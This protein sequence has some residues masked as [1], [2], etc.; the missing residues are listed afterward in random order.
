M[1]DQIK[2]KH[3]SGH[4]STI[5]FKTYEQ[6]REALA[7]WTGD[8]I[9]VDEEPP[10][11][12]FEE[13]CMRLIARKG[14]MII[15]FTPLRGKTK[16]YKMMTE[17]SEDASVETHFL[18]WEQ[19]KHLDEETKKQIAALFRSN[20]GQL[21]ARMTGKASIATGLIYPFDQDDIICPTFTPE[22]YWPRLAG[23]DV[24][25]VH[26]T[27]ALAIAWDRD[28]NVR[29]AYKEHR[30]TK[31]TAKDNYD[32]LQKWGDIDYACDPAALQGD[33]GSGEK[34]MESY[35]EL[36]Q[37]DWRS[38]PQ[39]EHR[40]FKAKNGREAGIDKVYHEFANGRL[41][42]MENCVDTIEEISEYRYDEKGEIYKHKDDLMDPLRYNMMHPERYRVRGRPKHTNGA[43]KIHQWKPPC[44]GRGA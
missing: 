41:F 16:L 29:Y 13:L 1:I 42:L 34:L 4:T 38:T 24:G 37:P 11:D 7:S 40:V 32:L 30:K 21:K 15:T 10:Q 25:W 20:P 35:L 36:F 33:K 6:G 28:A 39:E 14:Q 2:V 3:I 43:V 31:H 23:L 44:P 26:P 5:T 19:A 12:C 8:L 18:G 27:G 17:A 9:W 22:S